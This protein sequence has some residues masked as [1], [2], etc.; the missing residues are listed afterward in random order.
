MTDA[1]IISGA[2]VSH[3][4]G[5]IEDIDAAA[6]DSERAAVEALLARPGV[7]EA[8]ALQTCNRSEAF[9]VT[10]DADDGRAALDA[11]FADV[12]ETALRRFDHEASLRHLLRVACGLESLVVGED[13][14]I[15][16]VRSAYETARMAGG[17]GDTLDDA[18]LKALHVGE[19]ARTETGINEGV[20]SLGSAAARLAADE[21]NLADTTALVVGAGEMGTLA[22][23]AFSGRVERIIVANR[24]RE[25]ADHV[26]ATLDGETAA[27]A[28]G[29]DALAE[30]AA[31]ADVLV[32]ATSA[33]DHVIDESTLRAAGRTLVVDIA[34][35]RDVAPSV[36]TVDGVEVFDLDD[37]QSVTD[38]TLSARREAAAVVES[39]ID[40][41]LERLMA[42]YKRQRADQ[43]ISSMYE[44]AERM[45]ESELQRALT[46]LESEGE[47]TDEQREVVESMAD[48]LVSQLLAPPTRSLRDAAEQDDW[49]TIHTALQLFD[50]TTVGAPSGLADADPD[51]L[52]DAVRQEMPA[53]VLERLTAGD[54]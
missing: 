49:S 44:G 4:D 29:L 30:P 42:Q 26:A 37:L 10:A 54:E 6:A 16:Q 33:S 35:P 14:I 51:E 40:E 47:F 43:V 34:Q 19:R 9:V 5:S 36:A 50:P 45:K 52:P 48:A 46:K 8:Y 15:G 21:R 1:S 53:S 38:E 7:E 18:L 2:G 22:A 31:E 11:Q 23:Q 27:S 39:I 28:V 32:S 20:V 12:R 24:T 41:E 13:Q 3:Q 25:R 17:I